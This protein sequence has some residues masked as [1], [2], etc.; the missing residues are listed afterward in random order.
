MTRPFRA[1]AAVVL[2]FGCAVFPPASNADDPA[3][4]SS[5][6][7]L[8]FVAPKGWNED[9]RPNSRPGIWKNWVVRENRDLHS[10]V[11]SV[12]RESRTLGPYVEAN[13]GAIRTAPG[14]SNVQSGPATTCGDVAALA[15]SYRS[16]RTAGHP[17]LIKHVVV[18]IATFPGSGAL[19]GDV[20]YAHSPD[21]ADR[22]DA[23]DAMSTLCDERIYA[24]RG[25]AGW[26]SGGIRASDRPGVD[27]FSSPSSDATLIALAVPA[28]VSTAARQLQ[29]TVL[30]GATLISDADE[31]CGSIHV[32]RARW[33]STGP[34]GAPQVVEQ[35]AGY[36]HGASYVYVYSRGE[37]VPLDPAAERALT[38][39]CDA[40]ATLATPPPRAAASP[41]PGG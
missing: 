25:P 27:A 6:I 39:F 31:T 18:E 13:T 8:N 21:A 32:R 28:P 34:S 23:L 37:S 1:F 17:L 26:R 10:M 15:Y 12:T 36:R 29:P 14:I 7:R 5:S 38:S 4:G 24:M 16:D 3:P 22:A 19:I 30:T 9:T 41:A 35:V 2:A 20:S 33:R 11:L 40:D